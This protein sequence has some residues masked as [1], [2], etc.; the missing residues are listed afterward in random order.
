MKGHERKQRRLKP[1]FQ[2]LM[3]LSV[4]IMMMP[5]AQAETVA[6]DF[7]ETPFQQGR[8]L[9]D[10]EL[11][12]L[13]GKAVNARE[14]LFFG[15]EMTTRWQTSAGEDIH[16][17]ANL[18]F[19]LTGEQPS[20][21]FSS[22]I[23]AT[24]PAEYA[25]YQQ[26]MTDTTNS[27]APGLDNAHLDAKGVVQLAQAGGNF[28]SAINNFWVD[29]G[30]DM[31]DRDSPQPA[32]NKLTETTPGGAQVAIS[33]SAG[34]VGMTL[35]VPGMG[36]AS[37]EIRASQGLHQSIQLVSDHQQ[38]SNVTRLHIQLGKGTEAGINHE[39]KRLLSSARSLERR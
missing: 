37:Q 29:V 26:A 24:T 9:K 21:Q 35:S 2:S 4:M 14:I 1:A 5:L 11:S 39:F 6:T 22:H 38:I 13:R 32:N 23:T 17:R 8:Q 33:R 3:S 15:V 18:G 19:D 16:A 20:S 27:P 7:S 12:Q 28:N 34:G 31:P 10:H 25:A 30:H 36:V